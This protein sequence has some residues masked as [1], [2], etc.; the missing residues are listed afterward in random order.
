M[1]WCKHKK[2]MFEDNCSRCKQEIE[3]KLQ[4]LPMKKAKVDI[5]NSYSKE[6]EPYVL[7]YWKVLKKCWGRKINRWEVQNFKQEFYGNHWGIVDSR[8]K[9]LD[10]LVK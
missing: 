3:K 2:Q 8:L 10:K 9:E 5:Y 1:F 7:K 6:I 4:E